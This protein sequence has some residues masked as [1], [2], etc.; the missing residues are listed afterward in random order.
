MTTFAF[1]YV[2]YLL[3]ISL[4]FFSRSFYSLHLLQYRALPFP[5][6]SLTKT[7]YRVRTADNKLGQF[8]GQD[9]SGGSVPPAVVDPPH[10][11]LGSAALGATLQY[12]KLKIHGTELTAQTLYLYLHILSCKSGYKE[13]IK[14]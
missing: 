3:Y 13:N 5:S 7:I 4:P 9:I 1:R 11:Q 8:F 14:I 12:T 6:L 10:H 2:S